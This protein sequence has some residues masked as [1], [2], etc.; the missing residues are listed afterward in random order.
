MSSTVL[1]RAVVIAFL[2]F[3]SCA[4]LASDVPP[5]YLREPVFGLRLEAANV[6]LDVLSAEERGKCFE[7]ADDE[8]WTGNV[9]VFAVA[10]ESDATYY[11]VGGYF[12]R[13]HPRPG[14]S[15]YWL[16][17]RGGVFQI[18]GGE[19]IGVGAAREV[20]DVRPFKETPQPVLQQLALDLAERLARAFGGPDRLRTALK[21][22]DIDPVGLPP[23][24]A[25]AFKT[26]LER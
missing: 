25:E 17:S 14:E 23:E 4:A 3:A 24:L 15:P 12:R 7:I 10:R 13:R 9:W 20:F 11:V 1:S 16:D 19:C 18:K 6:K 26:Y 22:K 21:K 8:R 2:A 5:R